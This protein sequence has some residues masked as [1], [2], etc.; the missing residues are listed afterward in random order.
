MADLGTLWFDT[1]LK[2]SATKDADRIRKELN[3]KLSDI[4]IN[5]KLDHSNID[6]MRQR[7]AESLRPV[8]S[9]RASEDGWS[10]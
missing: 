3:H 6:A 1:R 2:D 5:I 10:Y 8:K 7:I 4:P 9:C